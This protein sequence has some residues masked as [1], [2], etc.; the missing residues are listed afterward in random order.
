MRIAGNTRVAT[1]QPEQISRVRHGG[2]DAGQIA[3]DKLHCVIPVGGE[4]IEQ[5][6]QP[7]AAVSISRQRGVEGENIR[8]RHDA[9]HR[10][11]EPLPQLGILNDGEARAQ[12][13]DVIGLAGGHQSNAAL[14]DLG[15]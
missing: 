15:R 10:L 1:I 11:F 3:S 13:R 6:S 4:I 12:T 9:A 2:A 5:F 14:G 8:V 7:V